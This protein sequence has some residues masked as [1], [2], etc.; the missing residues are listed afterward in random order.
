[1]KRKRKRTQ[2]LTNEFESAIFGE[3]AGVGRKLEAG[4]DSRSEAEAPWN[5]PSAY[6]CDDAGEPEYSGEPA[7]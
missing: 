4:L 5:E 1:M 3:P 6:E 7:S 2:L